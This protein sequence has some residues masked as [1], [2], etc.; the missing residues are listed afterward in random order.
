MP[1]MSDQTIY[2]DDY[3]N[4]T[5]EQYQLYKE[6]NV[7]P[8]DHDELLSVY[9]YGDAGRAQILAAVREFTRDGMYSGWHMAQAAQRRGLL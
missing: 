6:R 4:V 7:A 9:G 8:A 5:D 3:G 2:T 1:G